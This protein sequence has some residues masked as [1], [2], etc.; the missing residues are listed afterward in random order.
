MYL[1]F[2]GLEQGEDIKNLNFWGVFP[3]PLG[4]L[5]QKNLLSTLIYQFEH[6]GTP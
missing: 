3:N 1:N 2:E 4:L 5:N 6:F